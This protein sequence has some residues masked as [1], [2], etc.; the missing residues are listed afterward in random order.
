MPADVV[1]F[2]LKPYGFFDRNPALAATPATP[3]AQRQANG[4]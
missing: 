3:A 2:W 4:S 1:A